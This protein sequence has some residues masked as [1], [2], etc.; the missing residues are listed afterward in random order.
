VSLYNQVVE[1]PQHRLIQRVK[2]KCI[3]DDR[4]DAALT[5]GSFTKGEGDRYSDVEFWLFFTPKKLDYVDQEQWIE[6]IAP[7]YWSVINEYGTRVA[8][9]KDHLIRGEF[10]FVPSSTMGGVKSWPAVEPGR[11]SEMVIVDHTDKLQGYIEAGEPTAPSSPAQIER[12]CG[13]FL[14]WY[15]F[16]RSVLKR[17]D[18]AQA[19][20]ILGIVQGHLIWMARL[21]E[22]STKH[23]QTQSKS[24][25]TELSQESYR[26][27][28][29]TTAR[30][31]VHELDRAYQGAWKWASKLIHL[32]EQK[33]E[34]AIPTD[35][36]EA[37]AAY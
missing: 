12:L 24:L 25:E 36:I 20:M 7:I 11:A 19:H 16:G 6:D 26:K 35:L 30:C 22:G 37:L 14:N 5:Y 17:G 3:Q 27:F 32:L 2:D 18:L 13:Q 23:W 8:F 15:L 21:Q 10:H 31:D 29:Q 34:F 28:V 4:L 33:H 9:F 1:L